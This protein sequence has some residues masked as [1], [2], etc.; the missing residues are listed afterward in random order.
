MIN[1]K[2]WIITESE[3]D[4]AHL[5]HQETVFTLGNGY[6]G[7]RGA[8]EEGYFGDCFF[9]KLGYDSINFAYRNWI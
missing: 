3:F 4:P 7:V 9:V 6:L 5:H 2:T 8:F 1:D